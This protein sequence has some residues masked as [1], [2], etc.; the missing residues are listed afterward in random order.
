MSDEG[1]ML[2]MHI[3]RTDAMLRGMAGWSDLSW[4]LLWETRA[5]TTAGTFSATGSCH[6]GVRV[7]WLGLELELGV[8]VR[9]REL[10]LGLD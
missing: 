2:D 3:R 9:I 7:T 1:Q 6:K 8:E 10:R 4:T 5:G